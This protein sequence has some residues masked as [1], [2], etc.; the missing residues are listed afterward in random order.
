MTQPRAVPRSEMRRQFNDFMFAV[1]GEEP[2]L[3]PYVFR[4]EDWDRI[5]LGFPVW[6]GTVTPPMRTFVKA[7]GGELAGKPVAAFACQSGAG[8]EKAF[9]KLKA[10]LGIDTLEAEL[11]LIDPKDKPSAENDRKLEAFCEKLK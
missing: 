3:K 9:G 1:M 11:V 10:A 2:P 4:G 5:I 7:H 6:A 8:A